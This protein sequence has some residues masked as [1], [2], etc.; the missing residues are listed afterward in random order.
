MEDFGNISQ[1][2]V[3]GDWLDQRIP[4]EGDQIKQ[5]LLLQEAPHLRKCTHSET[6]TPMKPGM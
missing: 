5:Q 1:G 4:E 6:T 2:G 3:K